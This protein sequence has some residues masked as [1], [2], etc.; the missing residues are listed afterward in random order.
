M[1]P[2]LGPKRLPQ[3]VQNGAQNEPK[4][5]AKIS[6][7]KK[8]LKTLLDP[9]WACLGSFGGSILGSKI[10]KFNW[11]LKGF[12]KN[13]VF[14]EDKVSNN[15]LADLGSILTPKRLQHGTKMGRKT[16]PKRYQ[17]SIKKMLGF[18]IAFWSSPEAQVHIDPT[19]A[20]ACRDPPPLSY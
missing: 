4:S 5:N 19:A 11:F 16:L 3:R 6:I 20:K 10:I 7:K 2:I 15:I 1:G 14:E 12:V 13:H 18:F 17:K 9:S 8:A